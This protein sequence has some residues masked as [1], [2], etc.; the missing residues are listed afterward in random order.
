MSLHEAQPL[1]SEPL[2]QLFSDLSHGGDDSRAA[3]RPSGEVLR[4]KGLVQIL[5]PDNQR[6][7]AAVHPAGHRVELQPLP[8]EHG[9][10]E[11]STLVL[12]ARISTRL[13]CAFGCRLC[14]S[15]VAA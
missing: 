6:Q 5:G 1:L 4:A 2:L 12:S 10:V 13:G 15:R 8:A 7:L 3:H 11:G 14:R 9:T